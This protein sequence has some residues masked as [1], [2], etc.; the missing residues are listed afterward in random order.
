MVHKSRYFTIWAS[1]QRGKSTYFRLLADDL[2]DIVKFR[3]GKKQLVQCAKSLS[4]T[5]A[6]YLVFV[7]SG[8]TNPN[9]IESNDIEDEILIKT[10]IVPHN[11]DKDF[12]YL[13]KT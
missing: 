2:R 1:R 8:I 11:L 6:I 4:L 3:R 9:I 7:E 5:S 13:H 12:R 10:H